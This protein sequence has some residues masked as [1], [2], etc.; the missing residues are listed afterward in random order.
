M[1]PRFGCDLSHI[2]IHTDRKA[3]QS[4]RAVGALAYTAGNEVVFGEGEY[5]PYSAAGQ[6]LLAHELVHTFQQNAWEGSTGILHRETSLDIA[7][8][9][10]TVTAQVLGSEILDGF[11]LNSPGLPARHKD[12]L[13]ALAGRLKQLLRDHPLGTVVITGHTDATGEEAYNE[14][15]GQDRAE[16]VAAFLREA[17][18]PTTAMRLESAGEEKLRVPTERA[19]PRNRRVEIHFLPGLPESS[20]PAAES[21]PAEP[22]EKPVVIP[23]P[24]N[25]CTEH[26]EICEPVTTKPEATPSCSP[27][28]CSAHGGSFDEQPPDLRLI[29]VKSFGTSAAEWFQQLDVERRVAL[30]QIFN[31]MCR[32][33]LVCQVRLIVKVHAGE[34]PVSI[35][36]RQFNVPGHTPS[37]YFTSPGVAGLPKALLD[38]GRFCMAHGLGASQHPRGATLREISGS[39]SLHISVEGKDQIEAHIDRYSP[40]PEHTGGSFCSNA[41]SA[42]AVGHIGRELVSEKLRKILGLPGV[43]VFPEVPPQAPVPP[44]SVGSEPVPEVVRMTLRGPVKNRRRQPAGVAPLPDDLERFLAGEISRRIR[45]NAL[46]PPGVARELQAAILAAEQAGPDEEDALIAAR[47]TARERFESFAE[48]A[49]YFA[50][51]MARRMY[52]ARLS[53]RPDFAV[54]LGPIYNEL[55]PGDRTYILNQIRDMARIVR[56]LL[57]ERASGVHKIW[58]AFG[59]SIM[60]DID[61]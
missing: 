22:L 4:A 15:L 28:N 17:G 23:R 1:E 21:G 43:E 6:Q 14:R 2:R 42:A 51:D 41:P 11:K 46:V 37:V 36:D 16:A 58:A 29:L 56:A 13:H 39:D 5:S 9:S 52:Q 34:A 30:Q 50:Q 19:E 24:E 35:L 48:D 60:W 33:G 31:R 53:G 20:S 12:R 40:V 57:A 7:L 38:T 8:R 54:Q 59:E 26:P 3:A 49:H 61:F 27:E 55:Q 45:R 44:G 10:P 25:L 32:Y 18:V 47:E